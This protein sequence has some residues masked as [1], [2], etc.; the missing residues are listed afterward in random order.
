M[1]I[2]HQEQI[3]KA[4]RGK[5][6]IRYKGISKMLSAILSKETL[7]AIKEEHDI[8]KAMKG[9]NPQARLLYPARLSFRFDQELKSLTNKQKLKESNATKPALQ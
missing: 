1:K 4:A 9:I 6:Q 3:L 5:Q 2:K 8:F 7:Q